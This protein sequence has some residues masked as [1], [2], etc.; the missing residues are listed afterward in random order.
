MAACRAST[1]AS[2]VAA[3]PPV[4]HRQA[5]LARGLDVETVRTLLDGCGGAHGVGLRDRAILSLMVRLGL[6]AGEVARLRLD[7]IDWRRGEV[8][9]RGKKDRR[10]RLPLPVDVGEAVVAYLRTER[11]RS[12]Y[13]QVFLAACAPYAGMRSSAI[14]TMVRRTCRRSGLV[15]VGAH[16]LRHTAATGMLQAGASLAEIAEV[17]RHRSLQTTATYAKIDRRMLASVAMPWPG[18]RP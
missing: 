12:Q 15:E 4:C 6:R 7:D 5:H 3:V 11:P 18:T 1:P 8:V 13:R 10:E 14:C 9:V 16:R 17:L 2:L